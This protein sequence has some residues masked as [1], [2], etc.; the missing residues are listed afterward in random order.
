MNRE[1]S[2]SS[3]GS[4]RLAELFSA[5][6]WVLFLASLASRLYLGVML[7]LALFALLPALFGWH[8]TVVQSGSMEPHISPGD[9]VLAAPLDPASAVP[10]GGVVEYRSPAQAEPSG[11]EKI[12]LHRIVDANTDGTF[13]TAGDANT[14]VDSTPITRDQITGQARLLVPAVGL[15]GLWLRSGNFGALALWSLI[16]LAAV[17]VAIFGTKRPDTPPTGGTPA[18]HGTDDDGGDGTNDGEHLDEVAIDEAARETP[19]EHHPEYRTADSAPSPLRRSGAALGLVAALV[20]M[21]L[22]GAT[23]FSSAAFTSTTGNSSNTFGTAADWVPPSVTLL[24]PGPTVNGTVSLTAQAS[25]AGSGIDNVMIQYAPASTGI[26]VDVCKAASAPYSCLWSTAALADGAYLL[27]AIATDKAGLS[28]TTEPIGTTVANMF[29]VNLAD[30]GGTVRGSLNLATTL[31][32]PGTVAYTVRVEYSLADAN[33]WRPICQNLAA[34]Y[35]CM[36]NTAAL[37]DNDY[38]LRSVAVTGTRTSYS[39]IIPGVTVDNNG[40]SLTL[41]DPGATVRGTTTFEAT[42]SDTTSGVAQVQMQYLRSGTSTWVNMCVMEEEPY[43]CGFDT[44]TVANGSYSFRAVATDEAG[45]SSVSAATS[46]R[47]VDNTVASVSV[48]DPGLYLTGTVTLRAAANSTA[49]ITNVRIQTAPSGTNTWTTRCTLNTAPFTCAWNTA[50]VPDGAYDVRAVLLESTGKETT[51]TTVANRRVENSPLRAADIQALNGAGTPGRVDAGDTLVFS[52]SQQVNLSTVTPG[53]TGTG[54]P[55]TVRLRDGK[56][57]GLGGS[58]DTIDIQRSGSTVNLGAVNTKSNFANNNK[59]STWNGTM[60]ATT[61][62][63]NGIPRTV[64]TVTVGSVTSGSSTLR[65]STAS[66]NMIWTPTATVKGITGATNSTA[67]ATET[68]TL[69]RDF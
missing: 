9:V 26:W 31:S 27:R 33:N 11:I 21:T 29:A 32:N 48:E 12:R 49:G 65:S 37:S 20:A 7:S 58:A 23:A 28:T 22:L 40:P 45:N 67:P 69:D 13:V 53:W 15:P 60:T 16:T 8:G 68:G 42:A 25:D 51:S 46:Y 5:D 2:G 17:A 62:T 54:L 56:L 6:G 44:T 19:P 14:V 57:L 3:A 63:V 34:P 66:V 1:G 47:T 10:V 55:V 36:W 24:S 35:S 59:T 38:D 30:P 41:K 64:I 18:D 61:A 52:Y 50:G 43:A 4:S 39:A